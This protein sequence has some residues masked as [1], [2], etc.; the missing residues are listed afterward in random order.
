MSNQKQYKRQSTSGDYQITGESSN[1]VNIS[2]DGNTYLFTGNNEEYLNALRDGKIQSPDGQIATND[3]NNAAS[4]IGMYRQGGSS[5]NLGNPNQQSLNINNTTDQNKDQN[6]ITPASSIVVSALPSTEL[7]PSP[8][9]TPSPSL[10]IVIPEEGIQEFS[11]EDNLPDEEGFKLFDI[12][13]VTDISVLTIKYEDPTTYAIY[14]KT[15]IANNDIKY[16]KNKVTTPLS[17]PSSYKMDGERIAEDQC[18]VYYGDKTPYIAQL[19]DW[20]CLVT[21]I[22]MMAPACGVNITQD[23]FYG[24]NNKRKPP[25]IDSGDRLI[26]STLQNNFPSL[27]RITDYDTK[28]S[29]TNIFQ[30]YK[31]DIRRFKKP[32][33]IRMQGCSK[34]SGGH[35]VVAIGIT[36]DGNIIIHNPARIVIA[37]KDNIIGSNVLLGNDNPSK[38]GK[39]YDI[40]YIQ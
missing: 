38:N 14:F 39:N 16:K 19:N 24:S 33:V 28:L 27:K 15:K 25:Y 29:R 20:G 34:P 18:E 37:Y 35:Y 7:K 9:P 12:V 10:S 23:M 22:S 21:S 11:F 8:T 30:K 4:F 31:D 32:I 13:E 5:I 26:L 6:I 17:T 40:F 2:K 36:I 3:P 1:G